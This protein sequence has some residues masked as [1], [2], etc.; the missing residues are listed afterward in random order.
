MPNFDSGTGVFPLGD[1]RSTRRLVE[2]VPYLEILNALRYHVNCNWDN[3]SEIDQQENLKAVKETRGFVFSK[4]PFEGEYLWIV[5]DFTTNITTI[6]LESE[7]KE[8]L[9]QRKN[10]K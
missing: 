7:A 6:M 10:N 5:T 3:L 9:K 8:Y 4:F 2:K 1:V